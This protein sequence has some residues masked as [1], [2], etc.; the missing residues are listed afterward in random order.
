MMMNNTKQ[1]ATGNKA[2]N[3]FMAKQKC[4]GVAARGVQQISG[5]KIPPVVLETRNK[6]ILAINAENW[7][8]AGHI[9]YLLNENSLDT[10]KCRR[11]GCPLND[12]AMVYQKQTRWSD[13]H[14]SQMRALWSRCNAGKIK[15]EGKREEPNEVFLLTKS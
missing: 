14:A 6:K 8:N 5:G 13:L 10:L 1:Q 2:M 12:K 3:W 11:S 4:R 9:L 15:V 7:N